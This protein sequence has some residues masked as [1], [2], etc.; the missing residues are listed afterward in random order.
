MGFAAGPIQAEVA[1]LLDDLS[2]QTAVAVRMI[3]EPASRRLLHGA[4]ADVREAGNSLADARALASGHT[5]D[6]AVTTLRVTEGRSQSS[7]RGSLRVRR[8]SLAVQPVVAQCAHWRYF[9]D[10][11][12]VPKISGHSAR[13]T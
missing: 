5:P 2:A 9:R 6:V 1:K 3:P 4:Q 10:G 12:S 11:Q 13:K 7:H 8:T